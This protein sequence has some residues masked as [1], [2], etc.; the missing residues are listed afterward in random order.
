[1]Y[2][3]GFVRVE[4][5]SYLNGGGIR[6]TDDGYQSSHAEEHSQSRQEAS[7]WPPGNPAPG[8]N[9]H[10]AQWDALPLTTRPSCIRRTLRAR[11]AT[12]AS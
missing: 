11:A 10:V 2:G 1:M 3:R 6:Q 8:I 7:L 9:K 5:L 4:S 12:S